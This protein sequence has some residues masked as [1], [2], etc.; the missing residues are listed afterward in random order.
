MT[1]VSEAQ[2]KM[3]STV[4]ASALGATATIVYGYLR[5]QKLSLDATLATAFLY[6]LKSETRDLGRESGPDEKQA[7]IELSKLA[8]FERLYAIT[9]PKVGR[10][11]DRGWSKQSSSR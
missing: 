5:E 6:A 1:L 4:M 9:N 2:S 7:Y 10:E 8:D 11:G 3:V